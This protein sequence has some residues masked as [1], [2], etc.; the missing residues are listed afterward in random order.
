MLIT[1]AFP[2]I[3]WKLLVGVCCI[4]IHAEM[5]EKS[6]VKDQGFILTGTRVYMKAFFMINH[7]KWWIIKVK[8]PSLDIYSKDIA[9]LPR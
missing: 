7:T 9:C 8:H 1:S 6:Q 2:L 4:K 3:T 5:A